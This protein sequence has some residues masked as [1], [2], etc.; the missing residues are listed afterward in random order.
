M[1][2]VIQSLFTTIQARKLHPPPGS[3][4][5]KLFADGENEILKKMGEEVV[6][7]IVAA[8]GQGDDRVIYEM[9][10]LIYHSLVLLA[11]RGLEWSQIED[12]LAR[13][14]K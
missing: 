2:N 5:A 9:S 1:S 8:K 12:E 6:E 3:Y 13:R 11:E 4:T 7:V 10:D 14:V